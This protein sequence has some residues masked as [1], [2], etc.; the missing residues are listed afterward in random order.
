MGYCVDLKD[1]K[2]TIKKENV[3]PAYNTL[4][5]YAKQK[6]K[7]NERLYWIYLEDIAQ[8]VTLTEALEYCDF[9]LI[10]DDDG[11]VYD[12]D[13]IGENLG[14]HEEI[15]NVIAPYVND[16]SYMHMCGE[17]GEHWK[18]VFEDDKCHYKTSKIVWE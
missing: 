17:D 1:C 15:L 13:W 9:D 12:I 4:I 5:E 10:Y 14:D 2:F 16:G 3:T 6:L 11:N 7:S 8:S 18:W